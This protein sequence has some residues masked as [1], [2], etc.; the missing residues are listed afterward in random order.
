M[1]PL[2]S[3]MASGWVVPLLAG[4]VATVFAARVWGEWS[5]RRRW[6]QLAW[7]GGLSLYAI[8]TFLDAYVANAGW[9]VPAYRLFFFAASA[10]VGLLGLGTILLLRSRAASRIFGAFVVVAALTAGIAQF[11]V[12]LDGAA[13]DGT[14]AH[15]PMPHPARVAFL[16]LNVVG[17]SALIV[18]AI[19]SWWQTRRP[20]VLLI[21]IGA[22]FP[23]LGGSL[24]TL[25]SIDLRVIA[26]FLGI[27]VMFAGYMFGRDALPPRADPRP[28]EV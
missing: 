14:A 6:H 23:A 4:V 16:L 13:L 17:G 18:G 26:Q 20:G 2:R 7:A 12:P 28:A 15:V 11:A 24:S 27:V 9:N 1:E 8:A 10:N 3:R 21:G 25:T 5:V 22:L 19:I